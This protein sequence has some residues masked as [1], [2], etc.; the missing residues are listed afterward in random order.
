MRRSESRDSFEVKAML[1]ALGNELAPVLP[2]QV[3]DSYRELIAVGETQ[4]ALENLCT[5]LDDYEIGVSEETIA[6]I[7]AVGER[8]GLAQRYWQRLSSPS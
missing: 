2:S 8:V 3:I 4:V 6:A 7:R 5:N 1:N